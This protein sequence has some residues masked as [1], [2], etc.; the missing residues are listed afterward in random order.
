MAQ[1]FRPSSNVIAKAGI[2][3]L[4]V[5]PWLIMFI[6]SKISRSPY[7]TKVG[8]AIDQPIPFS[9]RHHVSELGL[10]CR[11][12]HTKVE[13]SAHAGIPS[14]QVCM[15][16]HVQTWKNS[17]LLKPVHESWNSGKPIAWQLVNKVP[18]FV[19]FRHDI[20][21]ERG[22]ACSQCHGPIQD[23]HMT[24]K[25]QAFEMKWCLNCHRE[26]EKFLYRDK[27]SIEKQLSPREQVF[28]LYLKHQSGVPLSNRERTLLEGVDYKA[29]PAEIEK[30]KHLKKKLGVNTKQLEDCSVCHH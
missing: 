18:E 19:Y 6:G 30:G 1:L 27:E 20:H 15:N 4:A 16:C 29:T 7:N 11:H 17:P 22:V 23:M 2:G 5:A 24:A 8:I 25:G 13:K 12:C 21:I 3:A 14:T 10:D 28:N 26:S 9:H